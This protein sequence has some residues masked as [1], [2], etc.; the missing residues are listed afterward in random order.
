MTSNTST[1]TSRRDFFK[2]FPKKVAEG[3]GTLKA[4]GDAQG[5]AVA[6][7]DIAACLAWSGTTCQ[8][9]Y[10]SCPKRGEAI[11]I[12]HEKP[13]IVSSA[14]DGCGICQ[15]ACESVNNIK[16]IQLMLSLPAR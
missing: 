8:I 4:E 6:C 16:A 12:W 14:C 9:C 15:T 10:L 7:I 3:I 11:Q 1:A 13:V 2:N 5:N